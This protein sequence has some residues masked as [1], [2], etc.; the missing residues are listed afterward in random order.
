M[1]TIYTILNLI[2]Q[3]CFMTKLDIKDAYYAIPIKAEDRKFLKFRHNGKLYN[4]CSLPNG[5]SAGPRKFTKLLKPPL[6]VL[7]KQIINVGAYID[8]LLL[9]NINFEE[10]LKS[11]NIATSLFDSLGFVVHPEKS[12]FTPSQSMEYLG[13]IIDSRQMIIY[14]TSKRKAKVIELCKTVSS[15]KNPTIRQ[16]AQ[17]LG[18]FTSCFPGVKYGPLHYRDL[19][20][21]KISALRST[22][23]DCD[24]PITLTSSA[25]QNIKWWW[26][27]VD[28]AFKEIYHGNPSVTICTD[29]SK[30]GWL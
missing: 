24:K 30:S 7:R 16:V 4:F 20:R 21:N 2:K 11:T 27:H 22:N 19:E 10:I 3:D 13:F 6:S 5:L 1:D 28:T 15:L 25:L 26:T 23:G 8:D 18:T 29:A 12:I 14:L 17:L 9:T